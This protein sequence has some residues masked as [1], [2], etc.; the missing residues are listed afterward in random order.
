MHLP[1]SACYMAILHSM[2]NKFVIHEEALLLLLDNNFHYTKWQNSED[3][4]VCIRSIH[5]TDLYLDK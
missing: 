2:Q 5:K 4:N 3:S 1:L